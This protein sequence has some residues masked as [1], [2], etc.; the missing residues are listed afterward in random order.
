MAV[1]WSFAHFS[2][3]TMTI[4]PENSGEYTFSILVLVLGAF[5]FT[6]LVAS[7]TSRVHQLQNMHGDS[8]RQFWLLRRYLHERQMPRP[9]AIR[10]LRYVEYAHSIQADLVPESKVTILSLLSDQLRHEL[11]FTVYFTSI[12]KHP[13]FFRSSESGS[14][15][16]LHSLASDVLGEVYLAHGDWIFTENES[17]TDMTLVVKGR[18][19]YHRFS[20]HLTVERDVKNDDWVCEQ[21]LWVPWLHRG[22]AMV[23]DQQSQLITVHAKSFENFMPKH[24]DFWAAMTAYAWAYVEWLNSIELEDCTDYYSAEEHYS[25]AEAIL[26]KSIQFHDAMFPEGGGLMVDPRKSICSAQSDLAPLVS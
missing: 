9:L 25:H 24:I 3:V 5:I 6:F 10:I 14:E 16:A 2:L 23:K 22:D 7:V 13:L 20:G 4:R 1:H 19:V 8:S 26:Q 17:A 18:V 21:V 15:M 12:L 11:A